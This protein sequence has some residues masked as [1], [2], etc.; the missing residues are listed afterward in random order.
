VTIW[1]FPLEVTDIQILSVPEV[2]EPLCV[3]MQINQ[4][5]IWAKVQEGPLTKRVTIFTYGTGHP[6]TQDGTTYLGT[7]QLAGGQ[8]VFHVFVSADGR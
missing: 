4:P 3:Q 5:C 1:K 6:I 7:Y 8:L 2:F